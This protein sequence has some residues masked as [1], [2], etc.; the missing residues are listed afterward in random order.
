MSSTIWSELSR[1]VGSDP[2]QL[3]TEAAFS[4]V[5]AEMAVTDRE[6]AAYARKY[7]VSSPDAL[8]QLI[9]E[10]KVAGHPAWEDAIAWSNLIDYRNK[11]LA[12]AASVGRERLAQ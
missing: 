9:R 1:L 8:E 12:A 5:S 6:I 4:W 10:G 11:L 3:E 2:A 7:G